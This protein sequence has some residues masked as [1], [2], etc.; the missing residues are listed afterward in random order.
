MLCETDI[1]G[2]VIHEYEYDEKQADCQVAGFQDGPQAGSGDCLRHCRAEDFAV[3]KF[4]TWRL[5]N[6]VDYRFTRRIMDDY[7]QVITEIAYDALNID[8]S[9]IGSDFNVI[10]ASGGRITTYD[11]EYS[12]STLLSISTRS[13]AFNEGL[14]NTH[15]KVTLN[16]PSNTYE[17]TILVA[18]DPNGVEPDEETVVSR[19]QYS[20]FT[21]NGVSVRR[22]AYSYDAKGMQDN[23]Y[24]AYSYSSNGPLSGHDEPGIYQLNGEYTELN[25][26]YTYYADGRIQTETVSNDGQ[27]A[28]RLITTY[29]YNRLGHPTGTKVRDHNGTLLYSTKSQTNGFGEDIYSIDKSG[30]AKGKEYDA[31]G[32]LISEFVFADSA[33]TALFDGDDPN[34]LTEDISSV[35]GNLNVTSQT[36]YTYDDLGRLSQYVAIANGIFTYDS[37]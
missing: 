4:R 25:Y 35:Y 15:Q 21:L 19:S 20:Y 3:L 23:K 36:R 16:N 7:G 32:K 27:A 5:Y 22:L 31:Y 18:V 14:V 26:D 34:A 9:T 10:I 12:G 29:F 11:Y 17:D 33:D 8:S 6:D 13:P 24:T 37:R 30:V 1:Q 2:N 28:T